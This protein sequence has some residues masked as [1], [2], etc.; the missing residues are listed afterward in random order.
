MEGEW[1]VGWVGGRLSP[2][3]SVLS[4]ASPPWYAQNPLQGCRHFTLSQRAGMLVK[5]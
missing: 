3:T 2:G 1:W 4:K 5:T